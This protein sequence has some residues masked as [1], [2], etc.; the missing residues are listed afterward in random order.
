MA[1][2][3]F[4]PNGV[5]PSFT[6]C[7]DVKGAGVLLALPFLNDCG[8]LD[9]IQ[10]YFTPIRGYY[11]LENIFFVLF[12]MALSRIK[13]PE[14]LRRVSPGEWGKCLGI[15]RI[16]E[17]KT[18]RSRIKKISGSSGFSEWQS[19][20]SEQWLNEDLQPPFLLIDGHVRIYYGSQTD[21]PK[22]YKSGRRLCMS[23]M[24]DYWVNDNKGNPF[25]VIS[26]ALT[27]GL[28]KA[29]K[30]EIVPRLLNEFKGG[31]SNEELGQN[32]YLHRFT[33]VYDREGYSFQF[34]QDLRENQIASQTYNKFPEEDWPVKEFIS[35]EVV[36]VF[37]NTESMRV[38]ERGFYKKV[39]TSQGDTIKLKV[40]EVRTIS[41]S[42]HQTA[43]ISTNYMDDNS[44]I[45][46]SMFSRWCQEN[47]FKYMTEH[48]DLDRLT[49]YS[50][51]ELD[52]TSMVVSKEYKSVESKIKSL[53]Y[54]K[55]TAHK[56]LGILINEEKEN[57]EKKAIENQ[58]KKDAL[59][60]KIKT[61]DTEIQSLKISKKEIPRHIKLTDLPAEE[62]FKQLH[63]KGK[64]Y[65]DMI[66]MIA[67]RTET[68]MVL[69]IKDSLPKDKI[70]SQARSILR[71]FYNS[72][73]DIIT[74]EKS[75]II[76]IK[77]HTQTTPS[78]NK[79]LEQLCKL[80]NE[81]PYQY[82]N[83]NYKIIFQAP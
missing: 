46:S 29:M 68:A 78:L 38:A 24:M 63:S 33:L 34:M 54:Q 75:Q 65:T 73:A 2:S 32:E 11:S 16:P 50:L 43:I 76:T 47:Y 42:G 44:Q 74:D 4:L 55:G 62:Q 27:G 36:L 40:R 12:F 18:L 67:Y 1:S 56:S 8:H 25:F 9:K 21:L 13:N 45:V 3:C 30:D 10:T 49:D 15:D 82:P 57:Q 37:G 79:T 6:S 69:A 35:K 58:T 66:K 51:Q 39:K 41:E 81:K 14:Q 31:P 17:S 7:L 71:S 72:D 77:I 52:G 48:F 60:D 53:T 22:R 59:F 80:L 5:E 26:T 23:S 19:Y 83:S 28:I 64:Q 70:K 20:L 61:L